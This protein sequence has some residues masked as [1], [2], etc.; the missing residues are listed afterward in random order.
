[1]QKGG[2]G[3]AKESPREN[4]ND[5]NSRFYLAPDLSSVAAHAVC[6]DYYLDDPSPGQSYRSASQKYGTDTLEATYKHGHDF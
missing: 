5:N 3:V 6:S 1:M 2:K 4:N